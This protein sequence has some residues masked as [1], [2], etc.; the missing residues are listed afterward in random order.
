MGSSVRSWPTEVAQAHPDL[1]SRS[2][3]PSLSQCTV[4]RTPSP[5]RP[6]L[7]SPA[8]EGGGISATTLLFA[9]VVLLDCREGLSL[10]DASLSEWAVTD[11]PMT[12]PTEE[13]LAPA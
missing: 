3:I 9:L 11:L 7:P 8:R 2:P 5:N 4:L 13:G 6:D 10:Y 12:N 1:S